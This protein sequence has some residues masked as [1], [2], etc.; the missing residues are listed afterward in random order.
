[1][2]PLGYFY[3]FVAGLAGGFLAGLL[4]IGGGIIYILILPFALQLIGVPQLEIVQYVIS[5]SIFGTLFASLAGNIAEIRNKR[6]YRNEVL[7]VGLLGA[8]SALFVLNFV[9]HTSWYSKEVFNG[10]VILAM[11]YIFINVISN[12]NRG[13]KFIREIPF[14]KRRLSLAGVAG[15]IISALSGLGGGTVIVPILNSAMKMNIKKAKAISLGMIFFSASFMTLFNLLEQPRL[16]LEAFHIGFIVF[17]IVVPLSIGVVIAS[18]IAVKVS[19]K[20]PSYVI[21]Y[22]FSI[23]VLIVIIGKSISLY[24]SL[25]H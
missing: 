6:F 24:N 1:M 15:G 14:S 4:G 18:P 5:N 3:L 21:S 2:E 22:I 11:I 17:P 16:K 10:V 8:I 12:S 7:V 13:N 9:V 23:F 25:M 19:R 20:F